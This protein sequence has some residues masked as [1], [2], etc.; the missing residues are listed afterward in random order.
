[1]TGDSLR[2]TLAPRARIAYELL[3]DVSVAGELVCPKRGDQLPYTRFRSSGLSEI[4]RDSCQRRSPLRATRGVDVRYCGSGVAASTN[5]TSIT[6]VTWCSPTEAVTS[7]QP[8]PGN[9]M[10]ALTAPV[11]TY[12]RCGET[13]FRGVC[14]L[15]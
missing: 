6:H 10:L 8:A 15:G 12:C 7:Q 13:A 14:S 2:R 11:F 5:R 4:F 9:A 1:M 3:C